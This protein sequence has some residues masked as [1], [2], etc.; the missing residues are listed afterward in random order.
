MDTQ[1]EIKTYIEEEFDGKEDAIIE[2]LNNFLRMGMFI[3]IEDVDT[4]YKYLY[5]YL[6]EGDEFDEEG[7]EEAEERTVKEIL[8]DLNEK[9]KEERI[10]FWNE[11]NFHYQ[12]YLD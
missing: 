3:K 1:E 10:S 7:V 11:T 8:Q 5:H 2:E 6:N 9:E 12:Y 4:A